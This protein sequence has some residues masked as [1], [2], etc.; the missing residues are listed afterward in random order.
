MEC[1]RSWALDSPRIIATSSA[2]S[3]D[4]SISPVVTITISSTGGG[5]AC[6]FK[7]L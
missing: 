5:K 4:F 3:A 7:S 6:P 2:V 1:N